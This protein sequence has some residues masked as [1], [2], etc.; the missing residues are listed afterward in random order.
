MAARSLS[1]FAGRQYEG[2]NY[3]VKDRRPGDPHRLVDS[4]V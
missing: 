4:S 1:P 2:P 3:F